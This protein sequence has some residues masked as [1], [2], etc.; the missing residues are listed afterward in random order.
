MRIS[1]ILVVLFATFF[2]LDACFAR[3]LRGNLCC[4][5]GYTGLMNYNDCSSFYHCVN[6]N[7]ASPVMHCG[8]GTLFDSDLQVCNWPYAFACIDD[9]CFAPSVNQSPSIS[10]TIFFQSSFVPSQ[11]PSQNDTTNIPTSFPTSLN[12]SF[13]TFFESGALSLSSI[14]SVQTSIECN[15]LDDIIKLVKSSTDFINALHSFLPNLLRV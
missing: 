6:G 5:I 1:A 3:S 11:A 2:Q 13:P 14:P 9:S 4:S 10:P 8:P 7:V 12:S 15:L